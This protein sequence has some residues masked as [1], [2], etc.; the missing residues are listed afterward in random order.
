VWIAGR[1][2]AFDTAWGLF[3]DA[4]WK[5][6]RVE[7]LAEPEIRFYLEQQAGGD[8]YDELALEGR[9]LLAVPRLLRLTAG[10][11]DGAVRSAGARGEDQRQAVKSL[12]LGTASDV[13]HLA[14]FTPGEWIDPKHEVPGR[15][16]ANDRCGLLASGL[17]G[18]A[19]TIGLRPGEEPSRTNYPWR[20]QRTAMILGAIAFEM[21]AT[22]PDR[23]RPEPN[24]VGVT[25]EGLRD[26]KGAVCGRLLE[27]GVPGRDLEFGGDFDKLILM[28][29][30]GVDFL[31]FRELGQKGLVWH[32]R[33]VQA[34]FAAYWA[35][36]FGS[37][38]DRKLLE[39]WVVDAEGEALKEFDEFWTFAAQLPDALV[40]QARW[41]GVFEPCFSP[42]KMIIGANVQGHFYRRIF[43]RRMI[44]HSFLR[45]QQRFPKT[46][47]AWRDSFF[48]LAT[49][50]P[51][52]RRIYQE[53]EGGFKLIPGGIC[54]YGADSL[55]SEK[56][57][58]REVGDFLLH[59]WPVTN[60][61]YAEFDPPHRY[62]WTHDYDPHP[63]GKKL[64]DRCPVADVTWYDAWC[65]AAW[66]GHRL[67]TDL[68]WEHACRGGSGDSWYFGNDE[69]ELV[70]HG[71]Y[72]R[73]SNN[74]PHP[75]GELNPN[76]NG[77][78]D[79]YGNIWEWCDD[80]WTRGGGYGSA[81]RYCRSADA[82][83][84]KDKDTFGST[85]IGFRLAR[86][87]CC[88]NRAGL[89]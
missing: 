68:E 61:M 42:P 4:A 81:P 80:R 66:C 78:Y 83:L 1:P 75:V 27:E 53:I 25:E 37:E 76:P 20:I 3:A 41:L 50:T 17:V 57:C 86:S 48:A 56:G 6:L 18:E 2:H 30:Q 23:G 19:A 12:K 60:E 77:L 62:C 47:A 89:S 40:D 54:P 16:G 9:G 11:L 88:W 45:M 55:T 21:F 35:M 39:G 74:F 5:F 79:M 26:F 65:F 31:L 52:Q 51:K 38:R 34:F 29:N 44:Y 72:H 84:Y 82:R 63:L 59:Q 28:N 36:K 49:G 85:F 24:L 43:L 10:I 58:D 46:I 32:D 22:N 33:T 73:N 71:W 69:D 70:K 67:P 15:G 87:F 7:P 8:W 13:Y 14:Y 64:E